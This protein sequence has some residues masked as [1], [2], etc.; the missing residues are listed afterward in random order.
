MRRPTILHP[1][2]RFDGGPEVSARE[3]RAVINADDKRSR[4]ILGVGTAVTLLLAFL[5]LV[6]PTTSALAFETSPTCPNE[7]LRRESNLNPNTAVP[8]SLELSDCRGFELVSP[9]YTEGNILEPLAFS[10]SGEELIS[11]VFGAFGEDEGES[12]YGS[13][14]ESTR[15][16]H[17]WNTS[18]VS[19]ATSVF[20][21]G[22]F[23]A[24]SS[25]L[26]TNIWQLRRPAQS[27]TASA[28]YLSSP[29]GEASCPAGATKTQ[30][31]C[32]VEIGPWAPA[33]S[34]KGPPNPTSGQ[35]TP[36]GDP[37]PVSVSADL[38]NVVFQD[39]EA[40]DQKYFWPGDKTV[41]AQSLYEYVGTH[42]TEPQLVG[43]S[44][45]GNLHGS[46]HRNEGAELISRCGTELGVKGD[47]YNAISE[48]GETVFF[49]ALAATT[50]SCSES[51]GT[52]PA[53]DELY[54]RVS[55]ERTLAISEPPLGMPERECTNA[56]DS[57]EREEANRKQ[58]R[59]Q[60]AS[61][62]GKK[63][64]FTTAQSLINEDEDSATDLYE[65][66]I[67]GTG[68]DAKVAKLIDVSHDLNT[69]EVAEVQG[70]ARVSQ[71]G[72][73]VY[74]VAKGKL[75]SQSNSEGQQPQSGADNLYVYVRDAASPEGSLSFIAT[76]SSQDSAD[77]QA[78]DQRPVVTT[79]NG[80]F[81]AFESIED[82]TPDD[83]SNATQIFEYDTATGEL[84]RISVGQCPYS[85]ASCSMQERF[86]EG[87]NAANGPTILPSR[88]YTTAS[89]PAAYQ[90]TAIS[91]DGM[92][93]IFDSDARLSES[94]TAGVQA[95][96]EYHWSSRPGEGNVE[97]LSSGQSLPGSNSP[98]EAVAIDQSGQD[99]FVSTPLQLVGQD[100]GTQFGIYDARIG[101]GFSAPNYPIECSGESCQ[102]SAAA[103]PPL[104][105]ATS[106]VPS[107]A[108]NLTTGPLAFPT[109]PVAMPKP[110]TKAQELTKTLELCKKDK[111]K[112][113]RQNCE[114]SA[115]KNYGSKPKGKS[116]AK[117]SR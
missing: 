58:G 115:R 26:G 40:G 14:Y 33:S 18:A 62:D 52:G 96:Y 65:E 85:R 97:L 74:F 66:E 59:F 84:A 12:F 34:T 63:V 50:E 24:A 45:L 82:L 83:A 88:G 1:T 73:H 16:P 71:D 105:S 87:G 57:A 51:G 3:V 10:P 79:P 8:Y 78:T 101:G 70:V 67:E 11:R 108:G 89:N 81:L 42:N 99:A 100:T 110:L 17:G 22:V 38:S 104:P 117:K 106:T 31:A 54:A 35:F 48:N 93:V 37:M 47:K 55:Q 94:A 29:P 41:L 36:I 91:D 15:T 7:Q 86:A 111:A 77:W 69:G 20:P 56:C 92:Y 46:P 64:F 90:W 32:F 103:P 95:A 102:G 23:T 30:D 113:K 6:V 44:N 53:V 114:R 39:E 60:G 25:D 107:T 43:V 2:N 80:E 72:S 116:R 49:T 98:A 68:V 4:G 27:V 13:V 112:S 75:T 9:P 19:P 109:V 28:Y 21:A 61:R 5:A 76:L